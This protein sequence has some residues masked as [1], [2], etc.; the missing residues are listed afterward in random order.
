MFNKTTP[1]YSLLQSFAQLVSKYRIFK[2]PYVAL[3]DLS[4][5]LLFDCRKCGD[6][7]LFEMAYLCPESQCP[8]YLRNGPCGGS[9]KTR[10]EVFNDRP[11]VWVRGYDRLKSVG[12]QEELKDRCV[13]AR[14]WDL[15]QTSSWLNFFLGLD[16]HETSRNDCHLH[17]ED[18]EGR[19]K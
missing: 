14:N 13:P 8:K 10:C 18:E 19:N 9:E 12:R 16:H 15:N 5:R 3:E 1:Y 2:V 17:W 4:K 7:A 11:C 6:C